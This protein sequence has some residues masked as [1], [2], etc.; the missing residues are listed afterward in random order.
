MNPQPACVS[1]KHWEREHEFTHDGRCYRYKMHSY[2]C[3][4]CDKHELVKIE[5]TDEP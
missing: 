3:E 5:P 1:C 2:F 4:I